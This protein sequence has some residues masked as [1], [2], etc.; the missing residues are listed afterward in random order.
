M[1]DKPKWSIFI[2][3][4]ESLPTVGTML[5][6]FSYQQWFFYPHSRLKRK[7]TWNLFSSNNFDEPTDSRSV[8]QGRSLTSNCTSV[9]EIRLIFKLLKSVKI[10]LT[11][12]PLTPLPLKDLW[13]HSSLHCDVTRKTNRSSI[14]WFLKL[15]HIDKFNSEI[16]P[17]GN[18]DE[19]K[20]LLMNRY[21]DTKSGASF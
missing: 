4:P 15:Q 11:G 10:K 14:K 21:W 9:T 8:K 16:S 12:S 5:A 6:I 2:E 20:V 19:C 7:K 18:Y 3:L 13:W 17:L 1:I